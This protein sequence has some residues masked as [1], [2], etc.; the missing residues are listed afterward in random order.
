MDE[1]MHADI[2]YIS[3]HIRYAAFAWMCQDNDSPL[4]AMMWKTW[5]VNPTGPYQCWALASKRTSSCRKRWSAR[6]MRGLKCTSESCQAGNGCRCES[7]LSYS[8]LKKIWSTLYFST[9]DASSC[10]VMCHHFVATASTLRFA[11]LEAC[12]KAHWNIGTRKRP[13]TR[14]NH[15]G[16]W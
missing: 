11:L 15:C 2:W 6:C 3:S 9:A 16:G 7:S 4:K 14:S 12:A 13:R 8:V 10:N 5:W 1:Q